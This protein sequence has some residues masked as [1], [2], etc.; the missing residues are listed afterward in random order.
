MDFYLQKTILHG[1]RINIYDGMCQFFWN[2]RHFG[3]N[4]PDVKIV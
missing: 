1:V 3:R 2:L 4:S